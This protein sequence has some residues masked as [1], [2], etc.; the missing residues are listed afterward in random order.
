MDPSGRHGRAV[1][2][3]RRDGPRTVLHREF[4]TLPARVIRPFYW[5]GSGR[6]Y[7]YLLTPTGGMLGGDR[8]DVQLVLGSGAQVCL[9]TA[10]ATK[11]HP[12]D[13]APAVQDLSID[14]APGSSLEY[15]PEPTILFRAARW[16]QRTVVRRVPDSQLLL[17]EAWSAGRIARQEIFHFTSLESTLEV[18]TDGRL[19]VFDRMRIAPATYPHDTPGLW[20]GR[21]HLLSLYLL[22][23]QHP[24]P[25]WLQSVEE[26]L[27]DGPALAGLSQLETPGVIARVLADDAEALTRATQVLWQNI[28]QGV[29]GEAWHPWRK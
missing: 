23:D 3:F 20:E 22:Q 2:A 9:T 6:A 1:L 19:S 10:S 8:L 11:V 24:A 14:L 26:H 5:E 17:L 28:R 12:A 7:L 18:Y 15:L 29:W 21:P 16:Q 25:A 13:V 4:T 27:A